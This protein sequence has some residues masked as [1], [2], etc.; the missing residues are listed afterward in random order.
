VLVQIITAHPED[1]TTTRRV[2]IVGAGQSGLQ[3]GLSLL[4]EGYE[5]TVM[6]ART[7]QE[8]RGGRPTSTQAMFHPALETERRY[9]LD[10]WQEEAPAVDAIQLRLSAPPGT[11]ALEVTAPFDD[12]AQSTDQRVKTT[13]WLE[14]FEQRG[15]IVHYQGVTTGDLDGLATLGRY[16]LVVVA[17]G[18]G[19]LTA[20]FDRDPNRSPYDSPQRGL[21]FAYVHGLAPDPTRP[22]PT[23]GFNAVPGLGELFVI[24]A[25]T[26]SGPCDILFW[27]VVPGG[28]LDVW[29]DG[30]VRMD[31]SEH[32]RRILELAGRYTPG[33]PSARP[34]SS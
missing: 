16:D 11:L 5:V 33:S 22:T 12:P 34:P 29:P 28:P 30:H 15:G 13:A 1:A 9:D 24:P 18:K 27:E 3:L 20:L 25:L 31:P 10:L 21:S 2:L 23:V 14:L 4:A 26:L 32:L 19:E 8:I 6:S 7:P 17:A